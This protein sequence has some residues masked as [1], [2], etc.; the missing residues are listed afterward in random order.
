MTRS[1]CHLADYLIGGSILYGR[2][3]LKRNLAILHFIIFPLLFTAFFITWMPAI[4]KVL[5]IV[6]VLAGIVITVFQILWIGRAVRVYRTVRRLQE[7]GECEAAIQEIKAAGKPLLHNQDVFF[8]RHFAFFFQ[9][10]AV[11]SYHDIVGL[12]LEVNVNKP[13]YPRSVG[14][15]NTLWAKR[16]DGRWISLH[17]THTFRWS[18]AVVV[19]HKSYA[20]ELMTRNP[21]IT[22][23]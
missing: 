16:T 21:S 11:V 1:C 17:S 18:A 23:E 20:A 15:G 9:S 13:H 8:G 7:R 12:R 22:W 4:I 6:P 14:E 3:S 2:F 19:P 10:G 5:L